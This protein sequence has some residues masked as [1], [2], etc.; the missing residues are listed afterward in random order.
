MVQ[1]LRVFVKNVIDDKDYIECQVV[2][3]VFD[4]FHLV[5]Q[6]ATDFL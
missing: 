4:V 5:V 2:V 1:Q 6:A 3:K